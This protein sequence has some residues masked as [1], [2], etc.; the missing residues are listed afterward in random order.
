MGKCT[1]NS[2]RTMLTGCTGLYEP[3]DVVTKQSLQHAIAEHNA[4]FLNDHVDEIM[5]SQVLASKEV[6]ITEL[7][8]RYR[9]LCKRESSIPTNTE[10]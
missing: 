9:S 3:F 4:Q 7:N 10:N 5:K 8:Y 6:A 2:L 1:D